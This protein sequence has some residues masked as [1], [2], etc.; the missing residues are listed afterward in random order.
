MREAVGLTQEELAARSGL[1]SRAIGNLE[2]GRASPRTGSLRRIVLALGVEHAEA[3][4]LV[5]A[6]NVP[7][8]Q[9]V[10]ALEREVSGTGK[11]ADSDVLLMFELVGGVDPGE[12]DPEVR[13]ALL[14]ACSGSPAAARLA[15]AVLAAVPELPVD[16][17][18]RRLEELRPAG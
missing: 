18:V 10:K 4:A 13:G 3:A 17:L 12:W 1:S 11:L 14:R 5:E 8:A 9:P 15:G 2:R 16:E 7:A 6:A